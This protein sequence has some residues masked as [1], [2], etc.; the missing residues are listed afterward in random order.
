MTLALC[1]LLLA[2]APISE[3]RA[4][5]STE[6]TITLADDD[7][8]S[9]A[10]LFEAA[11]AKFRAVELEMNEWRSESPLSLV[12]A[13]AG[14]GEWSALSVPLCEVLT[15]SQLA[16]RYT[17]GAFDPTWAALRPLWKF[18]SEKTGRV[19]TEDELAAS[20]PLVNAERLLLRPLAL[21]GGLG[22]EA[23]L[24]AAGM[25]LGLGGVAKGYAVDLAVATLRQAGARNFLVQAGG[26]LFAAGEKS[27][28]Q[29]WRVGV[30]DPRG[31]RGSYFA[32]LE[33]RDRAFSTS[34]DYERFFEREGVRYH[35]LIDP[36]TCQ[37]G[38]KS[39]SATVLA[40]TAMEAEFLTKAAFL[41]GGD[42]ALQLVS[43]RGAEAV[44]VT[45]RNEVKVSRGLKKK[46]KVLRSPSSGAGP[47]GTG[48]GTGTGPSRTSP[49]DAGR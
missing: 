36:S 34:G 44:L 18:G 48:T 32:T 24:Q 14:T 10:P 19:P 41:K 42:E 3:T 15:Q 1:A 26:D 8:A 40:K 29:P 47:I 35:H 46:L 22:C 11:F 30:Q 4:L 12:N 25:Q 27:P 16:H 6:V 17:G 37:P 49:A 2:S 33:V 38:R 43:R 7:P 28:G 20:C 5:M 9:A 23:Q 31:E 45:A 39:R 21:D 13:R